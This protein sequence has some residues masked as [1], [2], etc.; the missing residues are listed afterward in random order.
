[1]I[2]M[3]YKSI[4]ELDLKLLLLSGSSI[5]VENIE[6]TPYK[7]SEIKDFGYSNYMRNLQ[8][9]TISIDDFIDSVEEEDKREHLRQ[10]GSL[11]KAFDF[12]IKLGG[13]NFLEMVTQSLKMVLKT[14]DVKVI[15][16]GVI[17]INFEKMGLLNIDGDEIS[18]NEEK[19]NAV[20][21]EEIMIIHRENFDDLVD[22]VKLQ[23]F[24]VKPSEKK[25]NEANPADE[26]TRKLIEEM[27]K[28]RAKVEQKKN[29]QKIQ[30][31]GEIDI[32]DI[33]SAVSARSNSINKL[34]IWDLTLYQLYDEYTRLELIDNYDISIKAI[35]A[36]ADKIELKHWSSK[37]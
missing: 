29:A 13:P 27:D 11:L 31:D 35:M 28:M 34:N 14:D 3:Q 2:A 15:S 4:N 10:E 8:W 19:I 30:E 18:L 32:S 36:G 23:N 5:N 25:T 17:G 20:K 9:I 33:I 37:A 24:L 22:V 12:Y 7:L 16:E 26:E 21:E 6:I 1:V